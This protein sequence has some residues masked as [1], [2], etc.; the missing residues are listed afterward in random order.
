MRLM[1]LKLHDLL[2]LSEKIELG[3]TE[4]QERLS[5]ITKFNINARYDDYKK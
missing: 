2:Y 3:L 4:N 1:L 5:I